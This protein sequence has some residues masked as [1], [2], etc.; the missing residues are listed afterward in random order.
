MPIACQWRN[1]TEAMVKIMKKALSGALPVGKE[2]KYSEMVTLLARITF[3]I[4]SRPLALAS[5]SVR[6]NRMRI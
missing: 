5:V 6:V 3:S 1:Q 2:L 4:N